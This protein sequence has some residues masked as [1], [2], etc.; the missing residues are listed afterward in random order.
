MMSTRVSTKIRFYQVTTTTEKVL[1]PWWDCCTW[2]FNTINMV[3][4][5]SYC[6]SMNL[7][8]AKKCWKEKLVQWVLK[9][10]YKTCETPPCFSNLIYERFVAN[11]T[12]ME[13]S[14]CQ[15]CFKVYAHGE[16]IQHMFFTKWCLPR[17]YENLGRILFRGRMIRRFP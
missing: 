15:T 12:R 10:G 4:T 16:Q 9:T 5:S 1:E 7:V 11:K 6:P 8:V 13:L 17:N 3:P 2:T 14:I